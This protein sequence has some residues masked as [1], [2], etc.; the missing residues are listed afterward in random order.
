[1]GCLGI[2]GDDDPGRKLE[3]VR[4]ALILE[5]V[6]DAPPILSG[7][8]ARPWMGSSEPHHDGVRDRPQP[9]SRIPFFL[10]GQRRGHPPSE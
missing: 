5:G 6:R 1:M 4:A 7:L 3:T 9:T 8:D 2:L 10:F